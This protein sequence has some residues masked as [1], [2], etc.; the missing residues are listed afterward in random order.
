MSPGHPDHTKTGF[1]AETSRISRMVLW[2]LSV[3]KKLAWYR[4]LDARVYFKLFFTV[5]NNLDQQSL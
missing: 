3:F 1:V 5:S 2:V 4:C